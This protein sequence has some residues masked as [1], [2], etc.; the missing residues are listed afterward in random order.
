MDDF[1]GERCQVDSQ[2]GLS[3]S[4]LL[5]LKIFEP[6]SILTNDLDFLET[7]KFQTH[8]FRKQDYL[9]KDAFLELFL[10]RIKSVK[11]KQKIP[12][13]TQTLRKILDDFCKKLDKTLMIKNDEDI[14]NDLKWER[15]DE[16]CNI[17]RRVERSDER[18]VR[19]AIYSL[20]RSGKS[21]INTKEISDMLK[22]FKIKD[23][24]KNI[25]NILK[26]ETATGLVAA[27]DGK[28]LVIDHEIDDKLVWHYLVDEIEEASRRSPGEI[29]KE[30]LE[31]IDEGSFS[32]TE[33]SDIL[34]IDEATIS[35]TLS[36]LRKN[37]KI[38]LSS[39]GK[40]G[41][42]Y[43]T[44]NCENCPFGTTKASCRK[45]A[46]SYIIDYFQT[47]FGVD[48]ASP[49][50]DEIEENQALLKIKRIVSMAKK[51]K[52]TKLERSIA[53]GLGSLL[54]TAVNKFLEVKPSKSNSPEKVQLQTDDQLFYLP[55]LFHLGLFK[56]AETSYNLINEIL[57]SS[58]E[59]PKS[60]RIKIKKLVEE[61]PKKFLRYAGIKE[62]F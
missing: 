31:L 21:K 23:I 3:K 18:K 33:L 8:G 50:F 16:F 57:K 53:N 13:K 41:A 35:R 42:R 10:N 45:D 7:L 43:F 6:N 17:L 12:A 28:S 59:I 32:A 55:V 27:F 37:E 38:V 15:V 52:N 29:E 36:K 9:E 54:G 48:L 51:D 22:D 25:K 39:F 44:T 1:I 26:D 58:K 56:G 20:W 19:W 14:I 46:L 2:M 40:R 49:D 62:N 5:G 11:P 60:E 34:K 30:I 24:S 4:S 61:H 47:C